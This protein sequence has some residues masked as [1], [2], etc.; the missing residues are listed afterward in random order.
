MYRIPRRYRI[1]NA[2]ENSSVSRY[3]AGPANV[4][5]RA[6]PQKSH[7]ALQTFVTET[8]Q[9]A[10]STRS[11][12]LTIALCQRLVALLSS[13]PRK[14]ESRLVQRLLDSGSPLHC[15]RNDEFYLPS[16]FFRGLL[17]VDWI[18]DDWAGHA[19]AAATAAAELRARYR[20]DLDA[21]LA[22]QRVGIGV[23]VISED[24]TR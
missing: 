10:G 6:K 5:S 18:P 21:F 16:H 15:G 3:R 24:H 19:M 23:P 1:G 17:I 12:I 14:R 8:S 2:R 22:H 7:A 9:I 4:L 20:D 13:F 11:R